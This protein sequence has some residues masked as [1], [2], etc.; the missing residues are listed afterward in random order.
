MPFRILIRSRAVNMLVL[1]AGFM[2][3]FFSS[4]NSQ[5]L[6]PRPFNT[7]DGFGDFESDQDGDGVG[8]GW[9]LASSVIAGVIPSIDNT[10]FLTGTS[11]QKVDIQISN[12]LGGTKYNIGQ[13]QYTDRTSSLVKPGD[14][15]T[16]SF[17]FKTSSIVNNVKLHIFCDYNTSPT[18]NERQ[19]LL[20]EQ[21]LQP[22]PNWTR[23]T[24]QFQIPANTPWFRFHIRL[25]TGT[26][27]TSGTVW[28]D[29]VVIT[30]G[31][32]DIVP[33]KYTVRNWIIYG[34][35]SKN[36][37]LTDIEKFEGGRYE[38]DYPISGLMR[39]R[40]DAPVMLVARM[41][42]LAINGG[43]DP[44]SPIGWD[45]VVNN[46]PTWLFKDTDGNQF[47][48]NNKFVFV[49]IGNTDYQQ[50]FLQRLLTYC[51]RMKI[52]WVYLDCVDAH[53]KC[54]VTGKAPAQYQTDAAWQGAVT[55]FL[56][57]V[58]PPLKSAGLKVILNMAHANWYEEPGK[59]WT[60]IVDGTNYELGVANFSPLA[61]CD[62][63]SSW[64]GKLLSQ[65]Y[66]SDRW[67]FIVGRST[68]DDA[69][70]R[71][72]SLGTYLLGYS[73]KSYYTYIT[74]SPGHIWKKD[75][76]IIEWN[77]DLEVNLGKPT[78]AYQIVQ[79]DINTGGLFKREFENGMVLVNP[80]DSASYT[81]NLTSGYKDLD[82]VTFGPGIVTLP[83]K[84]ALILLSSPRLSI[85]LMATPLAPKPGDIVTYRITCT[86]VGKDRATNVSYSLP[87]PTAMDIVVGSV[88][89]GGTF[90]AT[91]H[92]V[93]WQVASLDANATQVLTCQMRVK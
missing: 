85:S 79:G 67:Y 38:P 73:D 10:T 54:T 11:S 30:D 9:W 15:V 72:F 65:V 84:Q 57:T 75:Q 20:P 51:S 91:T 28:F 77:P 4:S 1:V 16:M 69:L 23:Y 14:R 83:S 3:F 64:K 49:D 21:V 29:D 27:P 80:H 63:Y 88:S 34:Y 76:E 53:A 7:I 55:S 87:I 32:P 22:T 35:C 68:R 41:S 37:A 13:M 89:S 86:N 24:Y 12:A 66:R 56:R 39:I 71:R 42:Y 17:A 70:A 44:S 5:I 25:A 50:L 60:E 6:S 48:E 59:T 19:E 90:N 47:N 74:G 61:R 82:N 33:K 93:T 58:V 52:K 26:G 78:G 2:L 31:K 45:E 81:Y 92:A 62:P 46:H 43:P 36:N 40:P 8:D 18:T